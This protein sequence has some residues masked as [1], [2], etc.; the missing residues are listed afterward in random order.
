MRS[1]KILPEITMVDDLLRL[2]KEGGGYCVYLN[3]V[4][5]DSYPLNRGGFVAARARFNE[6]LAVEMAAYGFALNDPELTKQEF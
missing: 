5:M 3:S 1:A 6:V 2:Y 4:K